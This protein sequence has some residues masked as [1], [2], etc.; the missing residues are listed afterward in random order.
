MNAIMLQGLLQD[1]REKI[2][3]LS[4][5]RY[6]Y[7]I[8]TVFHCFFFLNSISSF[9]FLIYPMIVVCKISCNQRSQANF[10]AI[11]YVKSNIY[12][13]YHIILYYIIYHHHHHHHHHHVVPPA[14]I[15]LTVSRQSSLTFIAS[16]RSSGLHPVS[17]QS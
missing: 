5:H 9:Y 13:L 3:Y 16:G 15:S 4:T 11:K 12:L 10:L 7:T 6:L 1:D 14:R 17:S 8:L 2:L